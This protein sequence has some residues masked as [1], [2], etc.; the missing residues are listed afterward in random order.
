MGLYNLKTYDFPTYA[1]EP[2]EEAYLPFAVAEY[3][4]NTL[5]QILRTLEV[6]IWREWRRTDLSRDTVETHEQ[7]KETKANL[8]N[9]FPCMFAGE[10]GRAIAEL[11][12]CQPSYVLSATIPY[13]EIK[14]SVRNHNLHAVIVLWKFCNGPTALTV[15]NNYL[16]Q[17]ADLSHFLCSERSNAGNS[18]GDAVPKPG[19][20][21][22]NATLFFAHTCHSSFL[23][24]E[25]AAG[26]GRADINDIYKQ[27]LGTKV[28]PQLF[29]VGFNVGSEFARCHR[30]RNRRNLVRVKVEDLRA[31]T[32]DEFRT[33]S[34]SLKACG[35]GNINHRATITDT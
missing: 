3:L 23:G 14:D 6:Q 8:M 27:Q 9:Q 12:M 7:R 32:V 11:D 25:A 2:F 26:E 33:E 35:Q 22:K 34:K 31:L 30:L 10:Q 16:D 1:H 17:A 21:F 24:L 18:Q 19:R 28:E 15:Y 4:S 5:R 13:S 20:G 29:G